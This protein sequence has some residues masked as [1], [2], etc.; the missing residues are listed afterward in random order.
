M[1]IKIK[2]FGGLAALAPDY[3]REKGLDLEIPAGFKAADLV[4]LLKIPQPQAATLIADG[5][6]LK[7]EDKLSSGS[8]INIFHVM[9]GG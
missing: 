8:V 1:K 4:A 3:A 6:V 2:L 9:Y 5:H 7:P